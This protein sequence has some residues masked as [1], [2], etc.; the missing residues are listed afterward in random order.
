VRLPS[1]LGD[2]AVLQ[3]NAEVKLWGF[4][5]PQSLVSIT[6]SWNNATLKTRA[7][8]EGKWLTSIQTPGAGGPY[9]IVFNDGEETVSENIAIG[10]VWFCS[11]QSNMQML[12]RGAA[13]QPILHSADQIANASNKRLRLF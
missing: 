2:N 12:L 3:R 11:G 5:D 9:R 10:E 4:A 1:V 6:T 8:D 13:N 7:D